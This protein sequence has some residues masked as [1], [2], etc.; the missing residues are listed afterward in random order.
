MRH[1]QMCAP[2]DILFP[3]RVLHIFFVV[4]KFWDNFL[5][6]KEKNHGRRVQQ[7]MQHLA[8]LVEKFEKLMFWC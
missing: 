4:P 1:A 5:S 2:H 3:R 7:Q 6:K 8:K